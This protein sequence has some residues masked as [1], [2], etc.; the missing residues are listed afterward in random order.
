[1]RHVLG[2][3]IILA[4]CAAAT[5]A[6]VTLSSVPHYNW[7]HGC[8]PTAAAA[9]V[10]YYEMQGF[11]GLFDVDGWDNVKLTGNVTVHISSAAHNAKYDPKP[12]NESLP[13]P[14]NTSLA[15]WFR[16]SVG[17]LNYGWSYLSYADDAFEGYADYRGYVA[18]S[19]YAHYNSMTFAD[20]VTEI[21]AGRP[22]MFLVDSSGSG[23]TDHF[24]PIIG[25]DDRGGGDLWYA[26][27]T[28][29]SEAETVTWKHYRPMDSSYSWGIGYGIW[30]DMQAR[31]GDFDTDGGIIDLDIDLLRDHL[32]DAAFDADGD[33]DCDADD[34][35]C[36]IGS[37]VDRTDDG[38]GTLIGDVNL[39]GQ[40]NATDLQLMKDGF[41]QSAGYGQGNLN[42]DP[43]VNVTDLQL[44]KGVFGQSAAAAPEPTSLALLSL[45]AAALV[46]RRK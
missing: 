2:V 7:Y 44:L 9:V 45:G 3:G 22:M 19:S 12:D 40:V 1:M 33:G 17:S 36:L 23:G 41:G 25:Y 8:G 14:P 21:D 28:T 30:I 42:L 11:T 10:G 15:C 32:G 4:V 16:T 39:D 34:F 43:L 35:D 20:L 38:S 18:E 29:W 24:V 46:R 26:C 31:T 13:V 5:A 6:P 27:Y 37:L